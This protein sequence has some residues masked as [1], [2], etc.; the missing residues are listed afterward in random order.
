ME[1]WKDIPGY[2][3]LYQASSLGQIRS[4]DR[5]IMH[6]RKGSKPFAVRYKGR[7]L[8]QIDQQTPPYYVVQLGQ[9]EHPKHVHVLVALAFLGPRPEGADI[10]H[11]DGNSRNNQITNLCYGTRS[12]NNIDRVKHRGSRKLSISQV[13]EIR[14]AVAAGKS[15]KALAQEYNVCKDTIWKIATRRSYK[16]L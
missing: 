3:G 9:K 4:L 7:V 12:E 1:V 6:S 5:D 8:K 14:Q 10:R 11:L 2:E 13:Q 16:W 15:Y